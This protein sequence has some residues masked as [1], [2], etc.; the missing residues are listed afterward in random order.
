MFGW[1][2]RS[3]LSRGRTRHGLLWRRLFFF[4]PNN[5][6][7]GDLPA[8]MLLRAA[9]FEILL[10]KN[11]PPRISHKSARCRQEDVSGAVLHLD[12]APKKSRISRHIVFSV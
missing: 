6:L 5:V 7:V 4:E 11:R 2:P 12:P 3:R 8:E 10:E 9:L 1:I